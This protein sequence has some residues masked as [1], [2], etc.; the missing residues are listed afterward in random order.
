M[1]ESLRRQLSILKYDIYTY[2]YSTYTHSEVKVG[3]SCLIFATLWTK[4]S[5][6]FSRPEYWSG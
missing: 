3:Q 5:M 6:E 1:I 2:I 4:Q